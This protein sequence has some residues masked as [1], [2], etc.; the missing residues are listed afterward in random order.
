MKKYKKLSKEIL[1]IDKILTNYDEVIQIMYDKD[2]VM[3]T[4]VISTCE[5]QIVYKN[6]FF[7]SKNE[8]IL[9]FRRSTFLI[10]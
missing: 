10:I 4:E 7:L 6:D 2:K 3:D 1:E 5:T 9:N 8:K